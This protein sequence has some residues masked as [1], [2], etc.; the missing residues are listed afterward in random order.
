MLIRQQ[1]LWGGLICLLAGCA[2]QPVPETA[3]ETLGP[4]HAQAV[5]SRVFDSLDC[6]LIG[7]IDISEV[8]DHFAQVWHPA[9]LDRSMSL[10]KAEYDRIHAPI[11]A[12]MSAVLFTDADSN[13][14]GLIGAREFRNHLQRLILTLDADGDHEVSRAEAGLKPLPSPVKRSVDLQP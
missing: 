12:P 3:P 9:D 2:V 14:D 10:S 6:N 5:I 11:S 4:T 1:P 13:A 7:Q 8:D